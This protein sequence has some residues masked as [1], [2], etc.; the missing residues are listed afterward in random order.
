MRLDFDAE[1]ILDDDATLRAR[2]EDVPLAPLVA[3]V[4]HLTGEHSLLAED[5][6][7]DPSKMVMMTDDGYTPEQ[8][9]RGRDRVADALI[10]FRNGGCKP[11]P[12]PTPDQLRRL[13]EFVSGPLDHDHLQLYGEELALGGVDQRAPS[14]RAS[15]V[16]PGRA[17]KVAVIGAGMSGIA[18]AQ[19]LRQAGCS[20]HIYEKNGDVGGTWLENSY[21]GCRVDVPNHLYSYSFA[22]TPHW[23]QF[24]STQPVLFDYFRTCIA[25]FDLEDAISYRHEV[26][27]AVWDDERSVWSLR[28]R[29]DTGA[30]IEAE[31]NVVVSAVGQLNRPSFPDIVGIDSFEGPSFHSARWDDDVEFEGKRVAVIGSGASAVQFIPWLSER[32]AE[33]TVYQRTPGW[34]LPIPTYHD[35]LPSNLRWILRHVPEYARWD[36]LA[37]FSR[38]QE[39]LLPRTVVD[40]DWDIS[41]GSVSAANDELR[42]GLTLYYEFA[43]PDPAL[44]AKVLPNYPFGA[45]RMIVDSGVYSNALAAPNVTL[46]TGAIAEVVPSGVALRDG[47]TVEHDIIVYATGFSASRFLTP[48]RVVGRGGVDLHARWDGDARAHLGLT[49]PGFPNLFLMYGPNTNIVV[50]G[51]IIYFSECEAHYITESVRLLLEKGAAAMDCRPE[52]HDAYNVMIDTATR[53]RAWGVSDVSTW[54]R[55]AHGRVAQ[56]WPFN[57]FDYWQ[58]TR[59]VDPDDYVLL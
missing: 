41:S 21:P 5:L 22:Q 7:P 40:P 55:N 36:R 45:K 23:P 42:Q 13:I 34:I 18:A 14:W 35:D 24:N 11:G 57:L 33:V 43:F 17:V 53:A 15:E 52:V 6:R 46:E 3:A 30:V 4:A 59:A 12:E 19:R 28:I 16:A 48:M 8:V 31:V 39:G 27:E 58:Q 9:A 38:L 50:N 25:E 29:D 26:E 51:S 44:R 32:A 10:R 1:P 37:L 49:V 54:Y 56:N 47:R 2:L 20:V